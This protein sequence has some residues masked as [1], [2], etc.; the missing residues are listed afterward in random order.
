MGDGLYFSYSTDYAKR[1]FK[2]EVCY[3]TCMTTV[4]LL[5]C[6]VAADIQ[7]MLEET[8]LKFEQERYFAC[9]QICVP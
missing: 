9:E 2:S 7:T 4:L 6:S 1:M 3:F 8:Q 5:T